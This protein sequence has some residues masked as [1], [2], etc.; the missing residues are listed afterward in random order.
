VKPHCH[1]LLAKA[2]SHA[3]L[4]HSNSIQFDTPEQKN[5][6]NQKYYISG[7]KFVAKST[8]TMNT[9]CKDSSNEVQT[10][11]VTE[12]AASLWWTS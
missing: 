4:L 10:A 6:K 9:P 2:G 5:R 7:S 11:V 3:I 8:L 1:L 12:G